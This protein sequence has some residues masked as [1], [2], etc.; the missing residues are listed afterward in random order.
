MALQDNLLINYFDILRAA[1]NIQMDNNPNIIKAPMLTPGAT[2][3]VP[4]VTGKK[5][6]NLYKWTSETI[7][8]KTAAN[9]KAHLGL[10]KQHFLSVLQHCFSF[11]SC[12]WFSILIPFL[13]V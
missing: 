8:N 11:L 7:P 9:I 3:T 5:K 10:P 12:E 2:A 1:Q 6:K 13:G 4:M